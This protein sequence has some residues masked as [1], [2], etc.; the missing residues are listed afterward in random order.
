MV[1]ATLLLFTALTGCDT[2]PLGG[3]G[4]GGGE[5]EEVEIPPFKVLERSLQIIKYIKKLKSV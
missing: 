2:N 3:G 4:G 1:D 5:V